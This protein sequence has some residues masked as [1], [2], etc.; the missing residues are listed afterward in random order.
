[1]PGG[2]P[3]LRAVELQVESRFQT[4]ARAPF[5][6]QQHLRI[7]LYAARASESLSLLVCYIPLSHYFYE[8][9]AY[10]SA[11]TASHGSVPSPKAAYE[12]PFAARK[13]I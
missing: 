10:A 2:K 5:S 7:E 12:T 9:N 13:A 4:S 1:M 3:F 8:A 11:H 6:L